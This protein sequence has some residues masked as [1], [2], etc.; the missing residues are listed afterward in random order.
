MVQAQTHTRRR[1]PTKTTVRASVNP[2]DVLLQMRLAAS[3]SVNA[4][5]I[6]TNSK[7]VAEMKRLRRENDQLKRQVNFCS[8]TGL[9]S[10]TA[11][12]LGL[13]HFLKRLEKKEEPVP[14]ESEKED[15]GESPIE[16]ATVLYADVDKFKSINDMIGYD[17]GDDSI[18]GVAAT[19]YTVIGQFYR[20]HLEVGDST[21]KR[22]SDF[23]IVARDHGDEFAAV[24]A[25]LSDPQMLAEDLLIAVAG[26]KIRN[27]PKLRLTLSIGM[28]TVTRGS[29]F[30]P[31]QLVKAAQMQMQ[32]SK[33]AGGNR[34]SI[35]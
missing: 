3:N 32:A 18:V 13:D 7:L 30:T 33:A 11:F 21:N 10:Q 34:V 24:L 5:L 2:D 22:E 16:T 4:Q 28:V 9:A 1:R 8:L 17:A 25:N 14:S 19:L 27:H 35:A 6:A 15:P 31:K 20:L 26:R 12:M 23:A 29:S